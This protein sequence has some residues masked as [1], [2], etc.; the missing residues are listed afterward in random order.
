MPRLFS[1]P[2]SIPGLTWPT[3]TFS[4]RLTIDLGG[5]RGDL[6]LQYCGRGHAEGDI[7]A[8]LPGQQILYAGDL[9]EAQAALYT[10]DAFHRDWV[11]STLDRVASFGAHTLIGG[12]GAV[13]RGPE[14]VGKAI[15]QTRDFLTVMIAE[16]SE[17]QGRRRHAPRRVQEH[18][19]RAG[20]AVRPVADLRALP[21]VQ[22]VP[23]VGRTGRD[24][25]SGHL[26]SRT[27]PGSLGPAPGLTLQFL[28]AAVR[29]SDCSG[30]QLFG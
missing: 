22:S 29:V 23:S 5:D 20:A 1:E 15:A 28:V 9:V 13:T 10:G 24:R 16:V 18:P 27:R 6:V 8:W 30:K 25:A 14:A 7:I 17:V 4:D 2:E 3:L 11:T 19:R 26:D 12:R 21:A